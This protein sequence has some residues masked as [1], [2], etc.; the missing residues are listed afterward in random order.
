MTDVNLENGLSIKLNTCVGNVDR[1]SHKKLVGWFLID[2]EPD[3]QGLVLQVNGVNTPRI[4]KTINRQDVSDLYGSEVA[5]GFEFDLKFIADDA[6]VELTV[7]HQASGYEFDNKVSSYY[8]KLEKYRA[9][10]EQLVFPEYYRNRY[11]LPNLSN[12][13]IVDHYL[14]TG[15]YR[16]FD[17]NPGS[18]LHSMQTGMGI[19]WMDRI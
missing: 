5:C 7:V 8:G 11:T 12:T 13:E 16:N 3:V 4:P 10:L 14:S 1:C 2:G 19:T 6:W 17:P 15:I 18:L 9:T